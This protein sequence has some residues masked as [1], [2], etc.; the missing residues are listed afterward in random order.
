LREQPDLILTDLDMGDRY[1][2]DV[3][4]DLRAAGMKVPIIVISAH[5]FPIHRD[6]A[7]AAG[8]DNFIA[9]PFQID[10]LLRKIR[11]HLQLEWVHPDQKIAAPNTAS[12][13]APL[14]MH[15]PI[16]VAM[17]MPQP[18]QLHELEQLAKIGDLHGLGQRLQTLQANEP[19]YAAFVAHVQTLSKDF[20]LAD[21]KRLLSGP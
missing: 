17:Q 18:H 20:R 2:A 16:A 3:V 21:I 1:G 13:A 9:K 4:R 8:A 11:Q 19:H 7:T 15:E 12:T 10:E 6:E 14:A 5:A